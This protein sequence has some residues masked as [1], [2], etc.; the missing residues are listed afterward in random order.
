MKI[1]FKKGDFV[2]INPI[3]Q[4][5]PEEGKVVEYDPDELKHLGLKGTVLENDLVPYIKFK[6]ADFEI[7]I[8]QENLLLWTEPHDMEAIERNLDILANKYATNR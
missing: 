2:R 7:P 4:Y 8:Y 6:E 5:I 3:P 1:K